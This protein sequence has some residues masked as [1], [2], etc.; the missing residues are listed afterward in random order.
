MVGRKYDRNESF[1]FF[2]LEMNPSLCNDSVH[3]RNVAQLAN[4]GSYSFDVFPRPKK[5]CIL[6]R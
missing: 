4:A 5:V 1:V 2:Q 3:P 6:F